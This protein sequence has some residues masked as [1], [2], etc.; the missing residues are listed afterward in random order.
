M[1]YIGIDGMPLTAEAGNVMR[2]ETALKVSI[3][4]PPT[5]DSKKALEGLK[6]VHKIPFIKT[7]M[8]HFKNLDD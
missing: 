1:S 2:A 7:K 5:L 8:R 6:E 3:R 4:L